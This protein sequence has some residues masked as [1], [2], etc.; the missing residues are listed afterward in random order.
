MKKRLLL[1]V[2]TAILASSLMASAQVYVHIGPPPPAPR[3]VVPAPC[4]AAGF[5]RPD[6][7]AGMDAATFGCPACMQRRRVAMLVGFP[8]TGVTP[9][10]DMSGYPVTGDKS[11][12][13]S[14]RVDPTRMDTS[15][16]SPPPEVTALEPRRPRTL[17]QSL[18]SGS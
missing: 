18:L 4:I 16:L 7:T 9:T 11:D 15:A 8:V 6:I 10:A 13:R 5:G 14:I 12:A 3:E 2:S 17:V 1:F